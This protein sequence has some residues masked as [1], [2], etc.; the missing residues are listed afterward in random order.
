MINILDESSWPA[1]PTRF[2]LYGGPGAGKSTATGLLYA[3]LKTAGRKAEIVPE[4][5]KEFA[6]L[7]RKPTEADRVRFFCDGWAS[8]LAYCNL[9]LDVVT[10]SP[11]WLDCY[12][13]RG[14]A[15]GFAAEFERLAAAMD[16]RW[17][18]VHVFLPRRHAY[19]AEGR[20]QN[21]AEARLV[22]EAM[23]DY[24]LAMNV[25]FSVGYADSRGV[26]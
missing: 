24:L 13:I 8:E 20:Y 6:Y 5:I 22:D 3:T 19:Q 18:T 10:D 4:R 9:G 15:H 2:C 16:E 17:P 7:G 23:K 14:D 1:G 11:L 25:N 26:V 12:Y 21:E